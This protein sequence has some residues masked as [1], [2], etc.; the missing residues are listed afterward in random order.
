LEIRFSGFATKQSY[1]FKAIYRENGFELLEAIDDSALSEIKASSIN[2]RIATG[3]RR[4]QR[5]LT[6]KS[7]GPDDSVNTRSKRL[8]YNYRGFSVQAAT[9][10]KS[11]QRKKLEKLVRYVSRPP[12]A[13]DRLSIY[14]RTGEI[15][16]E[17]KNQFSDGTTH[18]I[19]TP[20]ELIAKLVALIPPPRLHLIRYSG[21]FARNSKHRK[22][23]V[24][25]SGLMGFTIA[26]VASFIL[27]G[28]VG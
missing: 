18:I 8:C 17:L 3:P 13:T 4:G 14:H 7:F 25:V 23:I 11:H 10:C 16:Y 1:F 6:L 19:I 21:V 22:L 24:K 5:I 27:I 15:K 9:Y 12:V 28:V 2:Y 20:T 26:I